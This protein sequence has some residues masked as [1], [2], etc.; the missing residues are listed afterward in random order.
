MCLGCSL[1]QLP[2]CK[3]GGSSTGCLTRVAPIVTLVCSEEGEIKW[4]NVHPCPPSSEP[5]MEEAHQPEPRA[6]RHRAGGIG[7][8]QGRQHRLRSKLR[9]PYPPP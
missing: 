5:Q 8:A 1:P 7:W 4:G 6:P 3:A 9:K 2:R